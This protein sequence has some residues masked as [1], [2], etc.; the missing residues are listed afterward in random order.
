MT[1]SSLVWLIASG[2]MVDIVG[3]HDPCKEAACVGRVGASES[4]GVRQVKRGGTEGEIYL[5]NPLLQ[6]TI[7]VGSAKHYSSQPKFKSPCGAAATSPEWGIEKLETSMHTVRRL[8]PSR[9]I[10]RVC[11]LGTMIRIRI[12]RKATEKQ[13]RSK[14][15][16][17]WTCA[18]RQTVPD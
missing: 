5:L 10:R 17:K 2:A 1:S 11:R 16:G 13:T 3:D 12:N 15:R 9:L 6:H 18:S 4:I 8:G 14:G 7:Q